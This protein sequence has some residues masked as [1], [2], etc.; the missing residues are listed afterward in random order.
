M[1]TVITHACKSL[2]YLYRNTNSIGSKKNQ[3]FVSG[4]INI[5]KDFIK[6]YPD[7]WKLMEVQ[8]PLMVYLIYSRSFPLMRHI[9][10][11]N[12]E[13][14]HKPQRK[15]SS[16][17]YYDNSELYKD[18]GLPVDSKDYN[19]KSANDLKLALKFCQG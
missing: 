12:A 16:Y 4:I 19:L 9:L 5:I 17:P 1:T 2:A 18:L 7:N 14:L 10:F 8:Y 15:Y 11:E 3:K 6:R 13:K